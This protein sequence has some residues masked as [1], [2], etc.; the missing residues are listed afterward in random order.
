MKKINIENLDYN[1]VEIINIESGK[2]ETMDIEVENDH[3]YELSDGIIS[4]NT[5]SLMTQTTSGIEPLFLPYYKRRRK[6][7]PNDKDSRVDFIDDVGDHWQEYVV[8][9]PKFLDWAKINDVK[10]DKFSSDEELQKAFEKSPYY[11]ACANDV[12]WLE[13]VELQGGVQKFV[14]HSISKCVTK[15]S[16]IHT[17]K[18]IFYI[19]ELT[20]FNK[21]KE[22]NFE[23]NTHNDSKVL[24]H[25]GKY[26][27]I[28]SFFNNGIKPVFKVTLENGL[29]IKCTGNEKL[30]KFDN[31]TDSESWKMVSELEIGDKIKINV[32]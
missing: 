32:K 18:G 21:I 30:M 9:H 5:V 23:K 15:D 3:Y 2:K 22:D 1:E 6:I 13:S 26:V 28:T 20:D 17:D 27:E 8:F 29:I 19:D 7:N 11:G 12:D 14:D 16:M 10:I 31:D 25:D 4:H 24:N